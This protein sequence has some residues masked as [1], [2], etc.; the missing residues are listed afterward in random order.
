MTST[1]RIEVT[2]DRLISDLKKIGVTKGDHLAVTLSFKSI[3]Y[4]VG[5]PQIL[6]DALLEAVGSEGTIMMN[7]H[8]ESFSPCYLPTDYIFDKEK[9]APSTGIVPQNIIKRSDSIRSS[10]PTCSVAC[11]GKMAE[12][13]TTGHDETA[14]SYLPYEK[15]AKID[16]KYLAIGIGN[17]LVAIRH[18]AQRRA[19]LFI[20]PDYRCVKFR[21]QEGNIKL[22]VQLKTPCFNK[23]PDLVPKLEAKGIIKR[24]DIGMAHS[25]IASADQLLY[26]MSSILKENPTLNLCD[27]ISCYMCRELER[28]MNL[29]ERIVNP[30]LF[31][32]NVLIRTV[33]SWRNR[34]LLRRLNSF[35]PTKVSCSITKTF[36]SIF[37][38]AGKLCSR[39]KNKK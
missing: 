27:G 26:H 39:N 36:E 19:G 35:N 37:V 17:R 34:L 23:L 7:T 32:K 11:I 38:I 29:Y 12:Y 6:I 5:G 25:I 21:D 33:L 14:N 3:G 9:T 22:H 8:T 2:K 16:G 13:L 31:Q 1:D 30:K 20:V 15:L 28:R 10:H 24:G 4:V 18:E